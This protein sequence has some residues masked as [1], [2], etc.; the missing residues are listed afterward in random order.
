MSQFYTLIPPQ[1]LGIAAVASTLALAYGGSYRGRCGVPL[2]EKARVSTGN[3]A[4]GFLRIPICSYILI[5]DEFRGLNIGL[6]LAKCSVE[7]T[8]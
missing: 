2:R 7:S 1:N 5:Y 3:G 4:G 6:V 8:P